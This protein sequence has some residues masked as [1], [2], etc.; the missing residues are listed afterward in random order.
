M[1]TAREK[2]YE[3]CV[4]MVE[5]M[6]TEGLGLTNARQVVAVKTGVSYPVVVKITKHLGDNDE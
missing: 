2:M 4:K 6:M 5:K 3:K 1:K